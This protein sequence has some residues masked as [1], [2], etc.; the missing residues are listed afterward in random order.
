MAETI[1][2][3]KY[4]YISGTL[5]DRFFTRAVLTY[6]SDSTYMLLG[7]G[8]HRAGYPATLISAHHDKNGRWNWHSDELPSK[9]EELGFKC[10]GYWAGIEYAEPPPP[11][12]VP[13]P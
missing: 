2:L 7:F 3:P 1:S 10:I 4:P 13:K 6:A 9:L 8:R 5:W 11:D 12:F